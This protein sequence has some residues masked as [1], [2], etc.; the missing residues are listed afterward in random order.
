[1]LARLIHLHYLEGVVFPIDGGLPPL[2]S[3]FDRKG[4]KF[5]DGLEIV[6]AELVL[7]DEQVELLQVRI[8]FL[9]PSGRSALAD[10]PDIGGVHGEEL[11]ELLVFV[12]GSD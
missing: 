12:G 1:L 2:S 3:M 10:G 5:V 6:A 8:D 11:E 7:V 4:R 9:C